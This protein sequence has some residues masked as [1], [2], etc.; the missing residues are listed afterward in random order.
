VQPTYYVIFLQT[1]SKIKKKG[2]KE[3]K[4]RQRKEKKDCM[5]RAFNSYAFDLTSGKFL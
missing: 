5:L 3:K 1:P 2:R 4:R